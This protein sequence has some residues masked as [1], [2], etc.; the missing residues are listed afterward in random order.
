MSGAGASIRPAA[1]WTFIFLVMMGCAG[2]IPSIPNDPDAILVKA[3]DY[4]DRGKY[5]QSKELY[6][7]FLS[8]YPGHS[9]SDEAQFYVAESHFNEG[10]YPLA[11]VEY[12]VL[13]SNYG[14]S[15]YVDDAFFK[16]ALCAAEE[17]PR[18]DLD[19]TKSF[20]ALSLFEQFLRTF[21]ASPLVDE[22]N[23]R[24]HEIHEK[25]AHKDFE[26]GHFYFRQK[27]FGPASLYFEK[28][29]ENYP[30]NEHWLKS[31]LFQAKILIAKGETAPA[32]ALLER[33]L[34]YPKDIEVTVEARQLLGTLQEE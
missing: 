33:V 14:Y 11:S 27:R 21:P 4:F 7:A 22:A 23:R 9:R 17:A 31:M 5:Y 13:S 34:E 15:D 1:W 3:R 26:N 12:R 19:Q 29:I 16:I 6:K 24:V 2:G 20:E 28:V 30:G 25:L 8:R 10:E 18:F 32:R